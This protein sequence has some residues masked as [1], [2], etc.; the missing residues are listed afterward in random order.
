MSFRKGL[1]KAGGRK[2]NMRFAYIVPVCSYLQR[3]P[4]AGSAGGTGVRDAT[5]Q[6]EY[7]WKA[8]HTLDGRWAAQQLLLHEHV[9][10]FPR[11]VGGWQWRGWRS[12]SRALLWACPRSCAA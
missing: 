11:A 4:M 2:H 5:N 8:G 3:I 1:L 7:W 6:T 12:T 10:T 9:S